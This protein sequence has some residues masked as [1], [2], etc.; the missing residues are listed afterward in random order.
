MKENLKAELISRYDEAVEALIEKG[1]T[2]KDVKTV[3]LIIEQDT[4]KITMYFI[5][6]DLAKERWFER[7]GLTNIINFGIL[8]E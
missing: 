8:K 6:K 5:L 7:K 2:V 3:N 4:D 1:Y